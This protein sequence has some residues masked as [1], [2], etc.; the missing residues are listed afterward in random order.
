M[1][2]MNAPYHLVDKGFKR[3][4]GRLVCGNKERKPDPC[5]NKFHPRAGH[6]FFRCIYQHCGHDI[7]A[8]CGLKEQKKPQTAPEDELDPCIIY[9]VE[10]PFEEEEV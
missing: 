6:G 3:K 5:A 4:Q 2:Y 10:D 7:C 1:I 9:K 8:E